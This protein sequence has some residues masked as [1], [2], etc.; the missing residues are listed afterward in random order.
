MDRFQISS[1]DCL[2]LKAFREASSLREAAQI[3]E[4]DPAGLVRKVQGISNRYGLINKVKNRWQLTALG[5]DL[6]A[7]TEA[8]MESQRQVLQNKGKLRIASTAWF[9][10][11]LMIP[12]LSSLYDSL[13]GLSVSLST[14][15]DFERALIDGS[16]DFVI[17]CHPPESPDIEYKKVGKE[18]WTFIFPKHWRSKNIQELKDL[19]LRPFVRHSMMNVDS[20]LPELHS[21]QSSSFVADNLI[22]VRPA[23]VAGLGWSFVPRILVRS[24]LSHQTLL[25]LPAPKNQPHRDICVWWLRN[26]YEVKRQSH[27]ICHWIK[28]ARGFAF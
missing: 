20:Y 15:R 1:D 6:V 19:E 8:S 4:C 2:I 28:K 17:V 16:S 21:L 12:H 27:Q 9:A 11:E 25:S 24:H 3:L 13:P 7:W 10:E 18:E 5:M 26:R 14:P 23:V 22:G